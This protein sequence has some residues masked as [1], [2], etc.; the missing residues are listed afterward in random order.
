MKTKSVIIAMLIAASMVSCKKEV[1]MLTK[2]AAVYKH[3]ESRKGELKL[4]MI[5]TEGEASVIF[6]T[7]GE[8]NLADVESEKGNVMK[9]ERNADRLVAIHIVE[10]EKYER[11][12]FKE[13]ASVLPEVGIRFV[14]DEK[15][16]EKE[17]S[18][19]FYKFNDRGLKVYEAERFIENPDL[20][21]E[22]EYTYDD[23][24]RLTQA[25]KS[26]NGDKKEI[27][28]VE[29]FGT[30]INETACYPELALRP[31]VLMQNGNPE[32]I[33]TEGEKG[34]H[35]QKI[36]MDVT[37]MGVPKIKDIFNDEGERTHLEFSYE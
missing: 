10:N 19:I 34:T 16:N 18:E 12:E 37:D 14:R 20:N 24:G 17:V 22:W 35:Y 25:I 6:N 33:R 28:T 3:D 36:A 23:E 2:S 31:G 11:I 8:G 30:G 9:F 7:D 32:V 5:Q 13:T 21:T 4:K 1:D 15:G 29:A 27:I 26:A